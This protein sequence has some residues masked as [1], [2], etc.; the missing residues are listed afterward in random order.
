MGFDDITDF[1]ADGWGMFLDGISYFFS[2][3][4]IGDVGE[5]FG[6]MFENMSELSITG[7]AFGILGAG[8]V[9][10]LRGYLLTPF[11]R[12]M[13]PLESFLWSIITYIGCFAGGYLVGK[14]FEND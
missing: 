2:F 11:T 6:S 14:H 13:S 9:I 10:Y 1:L 7:L 4:W 8:V 5:F 12:F 3:E